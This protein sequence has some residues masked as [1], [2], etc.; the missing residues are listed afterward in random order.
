[1][2]PEAGTT[3]ADMHAASPVGMAETRRAER[4][5]ELDGKR[6]IAFLLDMLVSIPVG[7][8]VVYTIGKGRPIFWLAYL[9]LMLTYFFLCETLTGQTLGKRVTGLRVVRVDGRPLNPR[10]VAARTV[11]RL[12]DQQ[13]ANLVGLITMILTGQRRQRLGDLAA[14]TAVTRASAAYPRPDRRGWERVALWGYP[15]VWLAPAVALFML[16]PDARLLPCER[17]GIAPGSG[18]EGSCLVQGRGGSGVF[19]VVNTGHTLDMPGYTAKLVRTS[20]RG[21]V[22]GFKLAVSNTEDGALRFDRSA[23]HVIL[24]V[25]RLDNTGMASVRQVRRGRPGAW[26]IRSGR[27]RSL[28]VRF[29]IPSVALPQLRQPAASLVFMPGAGGPVGGL[30]HL[31][32]IRLWRVSTPAGVRALSGLR[33]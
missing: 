30:E 8:L 19:T 26:T 29:A 33:D 4:R 5:R 31:G 12:L 15:A 10:S 14:R 3:A 2:L 24:A 22:V 25:P 6:L 11:L 32:E 7:A 13:I 28:W 23:R 18:D 17:T 27:T 1:V 9:A 16:F 20:T 21:R